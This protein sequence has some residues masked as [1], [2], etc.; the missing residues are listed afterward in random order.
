MG[1]YSNLSPQFPSL[2]SSPGEVMRMKVGVLSSLGFGA[3]ILPR[4]FCSMQSDEPKS[5]RSEMLCLSLRETLLKGKS[6]RPLPQV[7]APGKEKISTL[8]LTQSLRHCSPTLAPLSRS[9]LRLMANP[10]ASP[11][12]FIFSKVLPINRVGRK[13]VSSIIQTFF[14]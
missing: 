13:S 1:K 5:G 2:S 10:S 7:T 14:I 6:A 4:T 11:T 12:T 3:S 8:C 9:A